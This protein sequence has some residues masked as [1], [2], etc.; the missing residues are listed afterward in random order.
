MIK[1]EMEFTG[2]SKI[3]TKH[4]RKKGANSLPFNTQI[5]ANSSEDTTITLQYCITLRVLSFT[6][7]TD[8]HDTAEIL[9]KVAL[10]TITL[11]PTI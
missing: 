10:S 3:H 11:T 6:N 8:H 2:Y 9:L 1:T 5:H 7:K 4:R